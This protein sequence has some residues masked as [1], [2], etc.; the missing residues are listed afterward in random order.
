M[1]AINTESQ[2]QQTFG[3]W[4]NEKCAVSNQ[5]LPVHNDY[6]RHHHHNNEPSWELCTINIRFELYLIFKLKM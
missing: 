3:S 4:F 5:Q 1:Q 6:Y 2:P